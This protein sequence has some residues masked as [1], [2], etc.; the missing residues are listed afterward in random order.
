ME[1]REQNRSS[2]GHYFKY[3]PHHWQGNS[4]GQSNPFSQR[5]V[6]SWPSLLQS[7]SLNHLLLRAGNLAKYCPAVMYDLEVDGRNKLEFTSWRKE[8]GEE[9]HWDV[10]G[11]WQNVCTF[12]REAREE[13]GEKHAR[14]L[15]WESVTGHCCTTLS[16]K[17][18]WQS[19][20]LALLADTIAA[21]VVTKC[22]HIWEQKWE[23]GRAAGISRV[24]PCML[25]TQTLFPVLTWA[26]L[27]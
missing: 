22:L 17:E 11:R 6:A 21:Q 18:C 1:A 19:V 25:P 27:G 7:G 4:D 23:W 3:L 5:A 13:G 2:R 10:N 12:L 26:H 16:V 8:C 9:V 15:N 20:L 14:I 24:Q